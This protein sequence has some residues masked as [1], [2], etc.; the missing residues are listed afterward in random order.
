[1][2][3]DNQ[4]SRRKPLRLPALQQGLLF[5][6][7]TDGWPRQNGGAKALDGVRMACV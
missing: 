4:L 2:H 7:Q 5:A 3:V 6:I 1:M